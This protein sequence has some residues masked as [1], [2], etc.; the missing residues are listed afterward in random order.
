MKDMKKL[1]MF[2]QRNKLQPGSLTVVRMTSWW[3]V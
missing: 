2:E 3:L 1:F